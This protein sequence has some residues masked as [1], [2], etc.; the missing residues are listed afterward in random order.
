LREEVRDALNAQRVAKEDSAA[1]AAAA[2]AADAAATQARQERDAAK[3]VASQRAAELSAEQQ[4]ASE[5]REKLDSAMA[6]VADGVKDAAALREELKHQGTMLADA[7]ALLVEEAQRCTE[8]QA[9]VLELQSQI[10]NLEGERDDSRKEVKALERQYAEL[11]VF[12]LDIIARELKSV[13]KQ[14]DRLFDEAKTFLQASKKFTDYGASNASAKMATTVSDTST[15]LRGTV[16]DVI[17]RCLSETQKLHV[18]AAIQDAK[19]AGILKDGGGMCF[20]I[21]EGEE[22]SAGQLR[23]QDELKR[24]RRQSQSK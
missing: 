4:R 6:V 19:A 3:S 10:S 13:D 16:R 11:D 14:I 17:E 23:Q 7:Q 22:L 21:N 12:K 5:L 24:N 9:R 8:L 20:V 2:A 1:K 18:G 15:R